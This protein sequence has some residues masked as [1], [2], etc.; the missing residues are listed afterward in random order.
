MRF[1]N[2]C[3]F[4]YRSKMSDSSEIIFSQYAQDPLENFTQQ[5]QELFGAQPV[6]SRTEKKGRSKRD[7]P[8]K[9][10][11]NIS[12]RSFVIR[13]DQK[14]SKLIQIKIIDLS[15]ERSS[16]SQIQQ[17]DVESADSVVLS[18]QYVVQEPVDEVLDLTESLVRK[19]SKKLCGDS[20]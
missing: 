3:L 13:K 14:G 9:K 5:Y 19:I 16:L 11:A 15:S 18:A 4:C 12:S 2:V 8:T 7:V 1:T 17:T 20:Y 10:K 6:E